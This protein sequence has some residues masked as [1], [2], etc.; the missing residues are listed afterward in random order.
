[1][2][3]S[4]PGA[5]GFAG[6][7]GEIHFLTQALDKGIDVAGGVITS[8]TAA[9]GELRPS[10]SACS[11]VMDKLGVTDGAKAI[12]DKSG[13]TDALKDPENPR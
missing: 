6:C 11:Y 12:L 8:V 1:M 5:P 2:A 9:T 4:A 7:C 13:I 10:C 3:K